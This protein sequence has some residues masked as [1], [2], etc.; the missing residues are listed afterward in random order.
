MLSEVVKS[1][2]EI[3]TV[4]FEMEWGKGLDRIIDVIETN[5]ASAPLEGVELIV[6]WAGNDV[7]GNYD[8]SATPG[9]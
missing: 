4:T 3:G 5:L 1:N 8:T 2:P 6:S 9:T 7:Y